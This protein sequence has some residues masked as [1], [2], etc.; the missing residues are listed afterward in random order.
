MYELR[1]YDIKDREQLIKLWLDVCVEEH[2]FEEW[3]EGMGML[4]ESEYEKILVAIANGQ[5]IG[6]M[7]YKKIDEEI[8][9][10]KRVYLYPEHRGKGIA[11]KLYEAI[12]EIIKGKNYKK[13]LAETNENFVSGIKFYYKNNFKL[14]SK[15]N[16][17]YVFSLDI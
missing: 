13:I 12:L 1:E 7:A 14:K 5:V 10:L 17:T 3:R 6:S 2:G 11:K 15:D 4:D 8:A 9:E 16:E